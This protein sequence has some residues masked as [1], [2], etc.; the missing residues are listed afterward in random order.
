MILPKSFLL[1]ANTVQCQQRPQPIISPSKE[2]RRWKRDWGFPSCMGPCQRGPLLSL[3][4]Q[5]TESWDAWGKS[6]EESDMI[7]I[8][9]KGIWILLTVL[10]TPSRSLPRS[11]KECL[12]CQFLNS[13]QMSLVLRTFHTPPATTTN[14][15]THTHTHTPTQWPYPL[16]VPDIGDSKLWQTAGEHTQKD[17][18]DLQISERSQI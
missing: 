1:Q 7:L 2:K 12:T 4:I 9:T 10:Q 8:S 14:T 13:T 17:G 15:H 11:H 18:P 16:H 6:L 3:L 5:G